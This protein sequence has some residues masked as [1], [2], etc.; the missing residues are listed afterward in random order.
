MVAAPLVRK[1]IRVV[2]R[3]Q[4]VDEN[5]QVIQK[6]CWEIKKNVKKNLI[7]KFR[8][9]RGGKTVHHLDWLWHVGGE[10]H[11]RTRRERVKRV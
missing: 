8:A 7:K 6:R 1:P 9:R 11:W 10:W 2:I 5:L 4:I 3:W